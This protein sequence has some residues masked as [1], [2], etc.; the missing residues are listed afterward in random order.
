MAGEFRAGIASGTAGSGRLHSD[1][2]QGTSGSGVGAERVSE[3]IIP[4][5][6]RKLLYSENRET[7]QYFNGTQCGLRF[8]PGNRLSESLNKEYPEIHIKQ[9]TRLATVSGKIG[10]VLHSHIST[11]EATDQGVNRMTANKLAVVGIFRYLYASFTLCARFTNY[12]ADRFIESMSKPP[13]SGLF[14]DTLNT[15][16]LR[17]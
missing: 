15:A 9:D 2:A 14:G 1:P 16:S 17:V 3:R 10:K 12:A 4:R 13:E 7:V 5:W 6:F 8:S 11:N